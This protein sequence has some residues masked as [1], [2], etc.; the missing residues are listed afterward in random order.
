MQMASQSGEMGADGS[1]LDCLWL[2]EVALFL[3]VRPECL[4]CWKA[5]PA[6]PIKTGML[7]YL[8]P[9]FLSCLLPHSW[10][11]LVDKKTDS[12]ID[13]VSLPLYRTTNPRIPLALTPLTHP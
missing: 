2:R 7:H 6:I 9:L 8:C 1:S 11:V 12:S 13:V 3:C 5:P 10:S 4:L